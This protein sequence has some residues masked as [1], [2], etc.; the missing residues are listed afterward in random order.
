MKERFEGENGKRLLKTTLLAQK[1]VAGNSMLAEELA[2][3]SELIEVPE[4]TTLITQGAEDNDVYF[5]ISG[6][7]SVV[8][9]GRQ[10]GQR[11]PGVSLGEMAALE[12]IQKRAASIIATEKSVVCKLTEAQLSDLGERYPDIYRSLARDLAMRLEQRNIFVEPIRERIRVFVIS[13]TE[14]LPVARALH[15]E[16]D[17]DKFEVELWTDGVFKASQYAIESLERKLDDSDFAIAIAQPDDKVKSRDNEL[18][19]ARDNVIFEVGLF[20]GR[21]GRQRAFL[22]EPR[23]SPGVLPSDLTGLTT[24]SYKVQTDGK[25]VLG[26][27]CHRLRELISETGP[28]NK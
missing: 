15:A 8:V 27:C 28:K 12:P 17:H 6:S 7:F 10:V 4:G 5:I 21:L 16:F 25:P 19:T 24:L 22:L 9:N 23:D 14:A 13:S 20:I 3:M 18:L 11:F 26:P 1:I 2:N